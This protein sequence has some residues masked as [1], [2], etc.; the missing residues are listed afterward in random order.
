[1]PMRIPRAALK[2]TQDAKKKRERGGRKQVRRRATQGMRKRGSWWG[3]MERRTVAERAE[4]A[5]RFRR[6]KNERTLE[7]MKE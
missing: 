3:K 1:M 4:M 2:R 6:E 7:D 5:R